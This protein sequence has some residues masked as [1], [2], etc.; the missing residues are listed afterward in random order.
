MPLFGSSSKKILF[1]RVNQVFVDF[2]V[3]CFAFLMPYFIRFE[4]LPPYQASIQIKFLFPI[5]VLSRVFSFAAFS[6]YTIIWRFFSFRD[7]WTVL[8]SLIPVTVILGAGRLMLPDSLSDY[9]VPFSII[10]MEFLFSMVGTMGVR[11]LRRLQYE[12][13]RRADLKARGQNGKLSKTILIGAG[14]AGNLVAKE[15]R[16][17]ADLGLDIIG[18]IDDDTKKIGKVIQGF[19]VIGI[20]PQIPYLAHQ[21]GIEE[22]VI[23]IVNA[24]SKQIRRISELCSEAGVRTRIVPGLFE[25][26]DNRIRITKVRNI[27]ITDLLGRSVFQLDEH[28]E[29]VRRIYQGKRI[30]VTGAGGSI[31]SELC[32]QLAAL[33]P[34]KIVLFDK[35]ENSIF[36][37][38]NDLR[39]RTL[40]GVEIHPVIASITNVNRLKSVFEAYQPE[41]VFHAAAHKHV[42][43]MEHNVSEAIMNNVLGTSNL[44]DS[45]RIAGVER[46]LFVS[47]D[48]AVNPTNVMGATK[49]I[50]EIIVQEVAKSNRTHFSCVRF[51]NV[52]GS[53]GSVVP[54]F[55]K[56]IAM[57]GPVT[58]THPDVRRYF[59]SISEAV[60]LII[61]AMT[62]GKNG[63]IFVLDMGQPIKV[64]DLVRALV[65]LSGLKEEDIE[66]KFTGL[67]PGEKL[68]E[69]ILVDSERSM[70]TKFEKIFVAPATESLDGRIS[71]LKG[72][73]AAAAEGDTERVLKNLADM[74]IGYHRRI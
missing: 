16:Q 44:V 70:A 10:I 59:M 64:V 39:A 29:E 63:E 62:L 36:E 45:A 47:T 20:T 65:K 8:K 51:G 4:G 52:I 14:S 72:I 7:V 1:L 37:I 3:F 5:I 48:K 21:L 6:V 53:R 31:G 19:P 43:L 55:Q 46:F 60:H 49:R 11:W 74:G 56:Q 35:D 71:E 69:E 25:L 61:Q 26:L 50:G 24:S 34:S 22:A 28:L 18:F 12:T 42:P 66:I 32:R 9:R 68:Y 23:T 13:H 58:V 57:G 2:I 33:G 17:R 73:V 15:L 54:L 38:E 41:I 67:R 40:N 30:L 27:D